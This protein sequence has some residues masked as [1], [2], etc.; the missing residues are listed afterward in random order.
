MQ[1]ANCVIVSAVPPD[2]EIATTPVRAGSIA[3]NSAS[4]LAGSILSMKWMRG[5][6]R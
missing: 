2:F 1:I 4:K 6:A 5:C 3:A